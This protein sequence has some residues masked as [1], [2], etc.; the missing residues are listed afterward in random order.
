MIGFQ[1]T[2]KDHRVWKFAGEF[3]GFPDRSGRALLRNNL[4]IYRDFQTEQ[5]MIHDHGQ[6]E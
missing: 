5:V 1:E 4:A 3:F 2:A 6:E